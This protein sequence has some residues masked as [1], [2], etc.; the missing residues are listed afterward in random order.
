MRRRDRVLLSTTRAAWGEVD[1]R[2]YCTSLGC[3]LNQAEMSALERGLAVQGHEIVGAPR[4]ADLIVFNTCAVT[5]EAERKSRQ[6]LRRLCRENPRAEVIATGCYA[7]MDS[8]LGGWAEKATRVLGNP[9]KRDLIDRPDGLVPPAVQ[10]GHAELRHVRTRALVRVQEGCDNRCTYCVVWKLRGPQVSRPVEDILSEV[11]RLVSEGRQE[12]VLTGVHTGAYGRDGSAPGVDDLSALV[13]LLLGRTDIARVRLSSI[14][15]WDLKHLDP[16]LWEDPRL[17]RHLHVP[18]QSGSDAVLSR[19]RRRYRAAEYERLIGE[20]RSAWPDLAVTTD[21]IAGFPGETV[22]DHAATMDLARRCRFARMHVFPYSARPGTEAAS[23]PEPV[24]IDEMRLRATQL[25]TLAKELRE[26]FEDEQV[27]RTV[28]VLWE[29]RRGRQWQGL[30]SNYVAVRAE[31]GSDLRNTIT[32][33]LLSGRDERG[34]TGEIQCSSPA[35][36]V[37]ESSGDA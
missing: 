37:R 21:V 24:P 5:A 25:R 11:R 27:G 2:V 1:I 8:T 6:L 28:E 31:C 18:L 7:E 4:D 36:V 19:M 30:T 34:V 10:P 23:M 9:A 3:R 14:E 26:D 13:R 20:L 35:L 17:C 29:R 15:P 33:A 16:Q 12:V 32:A 22:G